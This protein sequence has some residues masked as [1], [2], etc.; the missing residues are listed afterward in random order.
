MCAG[1]FGDASDCQVVILKSPWKK[2]QEAQI[3]A[4]TQKQ[5]K[6]LRGTRIANRYGIVT[7]SQFSRIVLFHP[8]CDPIRWAVHYSLLKMKKVRYGEIK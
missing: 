4:F 6:G 2:K 3:Y 7:A 5:E 8:Y 1:S